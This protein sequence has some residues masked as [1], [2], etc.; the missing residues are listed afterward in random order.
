M[1]GERD[2]SS[3]DRK[4]IAVAHAR[5]ESGCGLQQKRTVVS[6][7]CSDQCARPEK[8]IRTPLKAPR[9]LSP[10]NVSQKYLWDRA[11]YAQT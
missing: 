9:P 1:A 5:R 2:V 6:Q 11:G 3:A 8:M 10:A 7:I 4:E